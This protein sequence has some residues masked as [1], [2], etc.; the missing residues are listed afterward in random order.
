M[1]QTYSN[2]EIANFLSRKIAVEL[3]SATSTP[4]PYKN[5]KTPFQQHALN[6]AIVLII[7]CIAAWAV[8]VFLRKKGVEQFSFVKPKK[9]KV[10]ERTRITARS[11]ILLVQYSDRFFLMTQSADVLALISEVDAENKKDI[12]EH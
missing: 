7:F 10:L 8:Y 1:N 2:L 9:I 3:N 4:I 5:S 11:S 12:N 6:E